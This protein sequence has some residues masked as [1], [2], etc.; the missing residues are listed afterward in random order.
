MLAVITHHTD[1]YAE[2]A[3]LTLQGKQAYALRWGYKF[4]QQNEW[5]HYPQIAIGFEK[6]YWIEQLMVANPTIEWFWFTGTDCLITNHR[7]ELEDLIDND[8]H[9]IVC[10]DD[11]GVN[12]D[13]FFIR[14]SKE[15][16]KYCQHLQE[17]NPESEQATMW[18]DE[19]EDQWRRITKYI[20]QY[21]M[22]IYDVKNYYPHKPHKDLL[23][24]RTQWQPGDFVLQAV[25]G[26]N[27]GFQGR[28]NYH[29]KIEQI[30]SKKDLVIL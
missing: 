16:L 27:P 9:F 4:F 1:N 17:V 24:Y 19:Q 23:G 15:G 25:T 29:W 12:A 3:E 7:L 30:K 14:N 2:L 13:V 26:Y 11:M 18:A 20:P 22:N 10:K 6:F 21:L 5:I 8:Y 28:D